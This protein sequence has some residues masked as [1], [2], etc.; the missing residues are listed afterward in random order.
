MKLGNEFTR[1]IRHMQRKTIQFQSV[2]TIDLA[3]L[4]DIENVHFRIP[5]IRTL[6]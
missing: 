1:F 5:Y 4:Y 6:S 2:N 3:A